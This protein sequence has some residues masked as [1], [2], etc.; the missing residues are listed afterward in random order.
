M[1]AAVAQSE[2]SI[3][4]LEGAGRPGSQAPNRAHGFR[5]VFEDGGVRIRPRVAVE[6][7]WELRMRLAAAGA[8]GALEPAVPRRLSTAAN[9]AEYAGSGVT[10]WYVNDEGG[11]EQGF[12]LTRPPG[13]GGPAPL[14]LELAVSGDLSPRLA[15][16]GATVTFEH[17][18]EAVL[19]YA[20]LRSWDARGRELLSRM[21]LRTSAGQ[22]TALTLVVDAAGAEYPVTVDP[23]VT[24]PSW[25]KDGGQAGAQVGGFVASA[26]VNGDGY[27]DLL[28]G[29]PYFDTGAVDAGR[30]LVY[31]GSPTGPSANPDWTADGSGAGAYF[32][33]VANA[34]DV[35][36][37][38]YDDV[39]VGSPQATGTQ[40]HEG[41]ASVFLGG[42]SGLS[43]TPAWT[44][45][46]NQA[47]AAFGVSVSGGGDVNGDGY[48]DV[49]VGASNY[50]NGE[51]GEGRVFVYY[52]SASGPGSTPWTAESNVGSALFGSAVAGGGDC[53]G[54]GFADVA[55]GAPT[56]SSGT[57]S[58]NGQFYVYHGSAAGLPLTPS[59]QRGPSTTPTTGGGYLGQSIAWAG[60]VDGDGYS[61]LI[62][63]EPG[64]DGASIDLGRATLYRG[65][66]GGIGFSPAWT[67]QGSLNS[68]Y[69]VS[70]ASAGDINGD[71]YA[72]WLVGAPYDGS[73]DTGSVSVYQGVA[74]A[75]LAAV[76]RTHTLTSSQ[77]SGRF[78]MAVASGDVDG[79]GFSDVV[80]DADG[81]DG[82]LTDEGR[83]FLYRGAP[84]TAINT[85]AIWQYQT[86][87]YNAQFGESVAL[88]GDV[89]GDGYP[90]V[91]VSYGNRAAVSAFYGTSTGLPATPSWT[92][93]STNADT[94]FLNVRPAGDVNGDGYSDVVVGEPSWDNGQSNEGR[95][96]VFLGSASGLGSAPA[97]AIEP[98]FIGVAF[99]GSVAGAGDVNGDGYGDVLVR[100]GGFTVGSWTNAGVVFLYLGSA[101]GLST[102]PAWQAS[103]TQTNESYGVVRGVGDVNGDGYADFAVGAPSWDNAWTD[104]GRVDVYLGGPNGPP[105]SP[106]WT[107]EG[108]QASAYFG[109]ASAA[110]DVNA[111]GFAD[112]VIVASGYDNGSTDE[113]RVYVYLGSSSGLSTTANWT[114]EPNAS[115]QRMT[116]AA[117]G[118]VNGDGYGDLVVGR[119]GYYYSLYPDDGVADVFFG[120][121][122]G[123]ASSPSW[124]THQSAQYGANFGSGVSTAGDVNGDGRAEIIVGASKWQNVYPGEVS[125]GAAFVY[126]MPT[127]RAGRSLTLR[128]GGQT[129]LVPPE[130]RAY[131]PDDFQ[132]R[133][134]SVSPYGRVRI[135]VEVEACP[136]GAA[137]R[138]AAC[139]HATS[140][141]WVDVAGSSPVTAT[142]TVPGLVPR[143][144]YRWRACTLYAPSSVT[145]PGIVPPIHPPHG[146]WR[147]WQGQTN[148]GDV[149]I[150]QGITVSVDQA[151]VTV[152]ETNLLMSFGATMTTSDGQPNLYPVTVQYQTADGT[153]TAGS[154][155]TAAASSITW[156]PGMGSAVTEYRNIVLAGGDGLAEGP[157]TFT[158]GLSSPVNAA[159]APPTVQVV[160]IEDSD[161][162]LV[163]IADA[164]VVEG[165]SGTTT[166]TFA[167]T[168]SYASPSA[169]S[170]SWA[171]VGGSASPGSDF[172]AAFGSVSIDPPQTSATVQVTVN[173]DT[174]DEGDETFQ[175]VLSSPLGAK[176]GDT[177][178]V[179]TI[180]N[181]DGPTGDAVT[182]FAATA[183]NA[184]VDLEWVYPAAYNTVR[185]RYEQGATCTAPTDP[186]AGG[187]S[188]GEFSGDAGAPG[189]AS[190]PSPANGTQYCYRIWTVLGGGTYAAGST[191]HARPIDNSAGQPGAPI[192][193]AYTTGASDVAPPGLGGD[194][195]VLPSN[196]KIVHA[197]VR[198]SGTGAGLWPA[199]Y[200]PRVLGEPVQHRPPLIPLPVVPGTT[201]FTL[202]GSQD[203]S[204]YAVDAR[205]GALRWRAPL[206]PAGTAVQGAPSAIFAAYGA[207]YGIDFDRVVA[208]TRNSSGSNRFYALDAAS[209]ATVG[210]PFDSDDGKDIGMV[211][212]SATVDYPTK[213]AYFTSRASGSPNT[214]WCFD[215]G[216]SGLS[217]AWAIPAGEIDASPALRGGVLYTSTTQG[218]V[219]AYR[220][221]NG[222]PLW[223]AASV[224]APL[225]TEAGGVKGFIFADRQTQALYFSTTNKVWAVRDDGAAPF[226][227][228]S[229]TVVPSPSIL[230]F[231]EL[232]GAG[233]VF[234]GGGDGRLY[235]LD[236][237][238]GTQV[239][240]IQ[241]GGAGDHVGAPTLDV[242]NSMAYVGST[243]GVVYAVGVPLP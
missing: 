210:L 6:G 78:G 123:L 183:S 118:D 203:G 238:T 47:D 195:V 175:V 166:I 143:T 98:D 81:Y 60:D 147:R 182:V 69:G 232:G 176:P 200:V 170:V 82:T 14:R 49:I 133:L 32:G 109:F 3:V 160:T 129:A 55:V 13:V 24:T 139:T 74:T 222:A 17:Q 16:D 116:A 197:V 110:G 226:E 11:L 33:V 167:V 135:K 7:T 71:G 65:G 206:L 190:H 157:E 207:S 199:N 193:W 101:A 108:D 130:G 43:A 100:A 119:P 12:T 23:L 54:D 77:A 36:G 92:F 75:S 217:R 102:S 194:L 94:V 192:A 106:S 125:E 237:A 181:D 87:S 72:D 153:A 144:L 115:S 9:R 48:A 35:N 233:Y 59:A 96:L 5:A 68:N 219:M 29:A 205:T 137:W 163:S 120:S 220:A 172:V 189:V 91:V 53:N 122:T 70:V 18:G 154:D 27:A 61:D 240:S 186:E 79:D 131:D 224:P 236:A 239:K 164:S 227:L 80:I 93:A 4:P 84:G 198:G 113:G 221:D 21:E 204:A 57:Y 88:A 64:W 148:S 39:I 37:D 42:P 173:G 104:A 209:G 191:T 38:G 142:A 149:R 132:V 10:E 127:A 187:T 66:S 111:D 162:P 156:S 161:P 218:D 215:L 44:A 114:W 95:A 211:S 184:R 73:T 216:A 136:P 46:G 234:V 208:G 8:S 230:A 126:S 196:D 22:E 223:M 225:A 141:S 179:G 63:G 31:H 2:Y 214:L 40:T 121:A 107:A 145:Q 67:G 178:A 152:S 41:S 229:T 169:A 90:D 103:G 174:L 112:V 83:V 185:I 51:P 19:S 34:G 117:A 25:V 180:E 26:D 188:L 228:W 150:D 20:G 128:G 158:I 124:E 1:Q 97:W 85:T 28:V 50:T 171:T 213:R 242:L 235:Q 86:N 89:N 56:Y 177:T 58:F 30:V 76:T 201:A 138:S 168:L 134:Q 146:P 165:N 159:L 15:D 151:V 231:L 45:W 99:G 243:A 202:L 155:Y 62:V 212:G 52:G 241:L 140:P 105:A